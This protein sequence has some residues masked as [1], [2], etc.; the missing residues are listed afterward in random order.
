MHKIYR[1][2]S[3][4]PF[5]SAASH[6]SN[7]TM[8]SNPQERPKSH[9]AETSAAPGSPESHDAVMAR[10]YREHNQALIRFL[11]T[12][13][14]SEQE[15]Q[16]VAHEAYV[17]MLQLDSRGAVSYLSAYLFKTAANI[18]VDRVRRSQVGQRV[19]QAISRA[20]GDAVFPAPEH[21]L[22]SRQE[23]ELIARY[24]EELPPKCRQAFYLHR[25]HDLSL[26]AIASELG[27][28]KRMVH[29]YL[30]R[31]IV[32]CRSRLDGTAQAFTEGSP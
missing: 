22:G 29:H 28:T 20:L 25:I 26:D 10:L 17:R 23:L 27:V 16:D 30:L 18:A 1:T 21:E 5:R 32:H 4:A 7:V 13:V 15:A 2:R 9:D 11:M 19:H 6:S 24:L 31:A 14:D 8:T 12:R 3:L